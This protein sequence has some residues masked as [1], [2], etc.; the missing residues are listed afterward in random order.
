MWVGCTREAGIS[1]DLL[2][3]VLKAIAVG[4]LTLKVAI[5]AG[6]IRA[7]AK[8]LIVPAG[9][10]NAFGSNFDPAFLIARLLSWIGLGEVRTYRY[11]PWN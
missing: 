6:N 8:T 3:K 1:L 10:S 5:I 9:E 7:T 11:E 2:L 4:N